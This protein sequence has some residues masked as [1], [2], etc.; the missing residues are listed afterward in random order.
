MTALDATCSTVSVSSLALPGRAAT[1]VVPPAVRRGAWQLAAGQATTLHAQSAH[2]LS[3]RQ[4][5]LWV[6]MDATATW[7]SEDL[8]L[9]PGER[10]QVPAGQRL[11]MEPW[12][13]FGAT[14]S[15]DRAD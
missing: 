14:W 13:G 10:L 4:G 8:V 15:W 2:V 6:T 3:V 9:G 12:D 5:R 11:V 1:A 7:G